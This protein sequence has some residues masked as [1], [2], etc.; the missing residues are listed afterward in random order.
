MVIFIG[1][2]PLFGGGNVTVSFNQPLSVCQVE[3]SASSFV[4]VVVGKINKK[5][6]KTNC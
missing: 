6:S 3:K 5:E 2:W 1:L 4:V